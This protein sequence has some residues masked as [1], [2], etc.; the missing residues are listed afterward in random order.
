MV[1]AGCSVIAS[2][3]LSQG[4]FLSARTGV[5]QALLFVTVVALLVVLLILAFPESIA[6]WLG[7]SQHLLPMVVDYLVWFSPSL[8][9]E[10]MITVALF[11]VRLSGSA[12]AGHVVQH[13]FGCC[14]CGARL[15]DLFLSSV[16]E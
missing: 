15:A 12:E 2:I 10:L 3:H 7:A 11:A 13:Y 1:G 6:Y 4:K 8:L 5:T 16:G 9:F 14:K